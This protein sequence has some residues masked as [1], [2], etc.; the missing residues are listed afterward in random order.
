MEKMIRN[1]WADAMETT[2]A[3]GHLNRAGEL[4]WQLSNSQLITFKA[5]IEGSGCRRRRVITCGDLHLGFL[6]V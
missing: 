1:A 6:P 4:T 5:T 3:F 2:G